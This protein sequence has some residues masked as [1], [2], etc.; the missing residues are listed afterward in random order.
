MNCVYPHCTGTLRT[1]PA[2]GFCTLCRLPVGVCAVCGVANRAFA[3]FCRQCGGNRPGERNDG[4]SDPVDLDALRVE[5]CRTSIP[6]QVLT[7]PHAA[8]GFLW[9]MGEGGDLYRLN[10]HAR[11]GEGVD[12]H[13]RFWAG[14]QPHAFHVARLRAPFSAVPNNTFSGVS[15]KASSPAGQGARPLQA[16]D[17]AV[18][19]TAGSVSVSGLFSRRRRRLLPAEGESFLPNARDEYQFVAAHDRSVFLLSRDAEG[20]FFCRIDLESG[21]SQRVATADKTGA[22]CGPILLLEGDA[23]YPV[24]WSSSGLWV[25]AGGALIPVALPEAVELPTAPV[26]G[27]LSLPPGRSPAVTGAGHLF[28]AARQF[29]RPA[30]LRLARGH[31]GWSTTAIA[32]IDRGT[33][34]ESSAGVP[35]LSTAGKLLVCTGSAFRTAVS[36][37]QISTRFPAWVHAGLTIFFCAADYR[38]L[39]QWI[40]AYMEG[41][42]IPVAWNLPSLAEVHTCAGFQSTGTALSTL[43]VLADKGLRTEFISWCA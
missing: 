3:L 11:S 20:I 4:Q 30:L 27:S 39:K 10:P 41:V 22:V 9:A 15:N 36:D 24:I 42:E 7:P 13:D 21:A 5:P 18:V 6:Q 35:L 31:D 25:Y 37:S 28:L 40:K 14:A 43:C 1:G 12:V 33:L 38:G 2:D 29:G 17:C 19:A 8:A 26:E 16:E 23:A 34:G 32:A